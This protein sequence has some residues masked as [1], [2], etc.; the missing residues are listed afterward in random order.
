[1]SVR[2]YRCESQVILNSQSKSW[3]YEHFSLFFFRSSQTYWPVNIGSIALAQYHTLVLSRCTAA[4]ELCTCILKDHFGNAF[5]S[6]LVSGSGNQPTWRHYGCALSQ[7]AGPAA[8][9]S[10]TLCAESSGRLM[11]RHDR[12]AHDA[13]CGRCDSVDCYWPM[14]VPNIQAPPVGPGSGPT[15]RTQGA[16]GRCG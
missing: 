5:G 15:S 6:E 7:Q 11:F 13:E 8:Q 16:Y 1:V 4:R 3:T 12:A 10:W 9:Y 14:L 2:A